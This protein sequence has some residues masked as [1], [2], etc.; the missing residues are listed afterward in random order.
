MP[1]LEMHCLY[2]FRKEIACVCEMIILVLNIC[3]LY[4][5]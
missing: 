2:Y 3:I 4:M 5:E 1:S